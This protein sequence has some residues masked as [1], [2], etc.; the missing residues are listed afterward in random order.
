M[1]ALE[2]WYGGDPSKNK[3]YRVCCV[4]KSTDIKR[5]YID[6]INSFDYNKWDLLKSVHKED[7]EFSEISSYCMSSQG[8]SPMSQLHQ[9][10]EPEDQRASKSPMPSPIA[11]PDVEIG[12]PSVVN[13]SVLNQSVP[14]TQCQKITLKDPIEVFAYCPEKFE[15]IQKLDNIDIMELIQSL[16]VNKNR[17]QV[18]K[19]GQGSGASGSLFFYTENK[20]FVIK[21]LRGSEKKVLLKMM[22][23]FVHHLEVTT[24][25]ESLL[26]RIYG[27]FTIR[28]KLLGSVDIIV[29]QNT[30]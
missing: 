15:A 16:R 24:K 3:W 5:L 29:M 1:V 25:N 20:K 26:A 4:D 10:P 19:A 9:S 30:A 14:E 22:D 21:T 13:P 17:A 23:D 7:E 18:F 12:N 28:S 27:I 11:L 8:H 2:D 6:N